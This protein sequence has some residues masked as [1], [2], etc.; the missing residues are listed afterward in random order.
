LQCSFCNTAVK[1]FECCTSINGAAS[2]ETSVLQSIAEQTKII[3]HTKIN[4]L[5]GNI[6]QYPELKHIP[7]IFSSRKQF[8]HYWF[9]YLNFQSGIIDSDS[10][11]N[12]IVDFPVKPGLLQVCTDHLPKETSTFHFII[13]SRNDVETAQGI[14]KNLDIEKFEYHPYYTGENRQF[15]E[16]NVFLNPDDI[17]SE[18]VSQ[19]KIFCNQALNFNYF[20][21]LNVSPNGDAYVNWNTEKLGSIHTHSVLQLIGC[22]LE[23]N[24]AWRKVRNMKPCSECLYQYLCPPPSNYELVTGKPNLCH[25]A[26]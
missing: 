26:P 13:S 11:F 14:I 9:H 2:L 8:I 6:F 21:K 1:Q 20:G 17:T 22:E 16:Q 24:T 7:D 10:H 5:G 18:T 19:R 25:V 3:P 23:I 15:F 4:I 12:I